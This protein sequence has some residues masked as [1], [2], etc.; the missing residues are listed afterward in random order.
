MID[1]Y[2]SQS[3]EETFETAA[4]LA[5]RLKRGDIVALNGDLGAGKTVF[6]KGIASGLGITDELTS[7]TF[8]IMEVYDAGIP[9]YHFDLYRIENINEFAQ[10][11]FEEYWEGDGVSVIEWP[12]KCGDLLPE[13]RIDVNIGYI[14]ENRRRITIEYTG[15]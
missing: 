7:P 14:D 11:R 15:Y 8:N 4:R 9:L 10:L 12:E 5:S 13:R 6:A 1:E 2:I 3:P